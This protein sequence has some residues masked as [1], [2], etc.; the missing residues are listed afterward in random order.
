MADDMYRNVDAAGLERLVADLF[1]HAELS[2][3]DAVFM[4]ECLVNADLR[5]V[6]S[7]GARWAP[8]YVV[9]LK[10]GHLN[11]HAKAKIVVDRVAVA[12]VD[13]D[14]GVGHIAVKFAMD[15]AIAKAKQFGNATVGIRNNGHCGAVAYYAQQAADAG[16]IGFAA[17]TGGTM[18]APWGGL[19]RRV[20]LNP[21]SWAAPTGLG[22]SYNLDMAPSIVAGSKIEMARD[23]G[24]SI[25]AEWGYD[26]EGN[27]TT[28]PSDIMPGGGTLA[29]VGGYK[30]VGLGIGA[31]ILCSIL[32]GGRYHE[33]QDPTVGGGMIVQ[34]IDI[35]H[36]QPLAEF[37]GR[38]DRM[39]AYYKSG[40]KR[41][42][43]D[44]VYL[45]GELES[46]RL[47]ARILSGI[48]LDEPTRSSLR[49]AA[50]EAGIA[51]EIEL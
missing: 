20:G 28:N 6:H 23:R 44:D 46:G 31:D 10:A 17:T 8:R 34:A 27:P 51:Y 45:P 36:F 2:T 39:V 32:T 37:T 4:G 38:M 12:I 16:C 11:P 13:G 47:H 9:S 50:E 19:D 49:K 35:E 5:G 41:S 7:H 29:G 1:R 3:E 15:V 14:R 43:V 40:R 33:G 21:I 30:G 18:I 26:V 25:P 24:E 22:F 48:P 42:L